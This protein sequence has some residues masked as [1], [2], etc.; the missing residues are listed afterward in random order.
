MNCSRCP[1]Q[2]VDHKSSWSKDEALRLNWFAEIDFSKRPP[3]SRATRTVF[4]ELFD[5]GARYS[6]GFSSFF[7]PS[8]DEFSTHL[9]RLND[10]ISNERTIADST[11]Y[12]AIDP[13]PSKT[14]DDRCKAEAQE[15]KQLLEPLYLEFR[16]ADSPESA[17]LLI[18]HIEG[19][20]KTTAHRMEDSRR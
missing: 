2:T 4:P 7:E 14:L 11:F 9:N 15:A 18:Q 19:R 16:L 3:I 17:R 12:N 5:N 10:L 6:A 20:E 1:N 13:Y 8:N